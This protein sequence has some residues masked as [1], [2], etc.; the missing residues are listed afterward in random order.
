MSVTDPAERAGRIV[1]ER[2][3]EA[4]AKTWTIDVRMVESWL[5][6]ALGRPAFP[7]ELNAAR[8]EYAR[9]AGRP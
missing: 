2:L 5:A 4:S 3:A 7:L 1:R 8:D 9:K 6:A